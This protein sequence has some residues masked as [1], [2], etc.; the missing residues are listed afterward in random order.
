[1]L[2]ESDLGDGSLFSPGWSIVGIITFSGC[3]RPRFPWK[4]ASR[5]FCSLGLTC[6]SYLEVL[7]LESDWIS[8][9]GKH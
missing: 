1:M 9:S 6:K 2:L 3:T 5:W 7:G 8:A 4:A